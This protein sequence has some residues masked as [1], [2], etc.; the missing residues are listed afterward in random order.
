MW[1][2]KLHGYF[3]YLLYLFMYQGNIQTYVGVYNYC[4][5]IFTFGFT[6]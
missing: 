1:A 5:Y 2:N 3:I 6:L 4:W